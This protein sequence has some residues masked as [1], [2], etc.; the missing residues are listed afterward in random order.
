MKS[1]TACLALASSILQSGSDVTLLDY[2]D[3]AGSSGR[4]DKGCAVAALHT[5][6]LLASDGTEL[7]I[8]HWKGT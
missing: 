8:C 5:D 1:S 6:T 7:R 2:S 3:S 4:G